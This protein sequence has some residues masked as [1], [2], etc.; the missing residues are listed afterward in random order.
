MLK[1]F[2]EIQQIT[3]ETFSTSDELEEVDRKKLLL[4]AKRG[5][6]VILDV[7]P[8]DEFN[9]AHIPYAVSVPLSSLQKYLKTLPKNKEIVAYCRGPYCFLAKDAV[10]LLRSKGF[11]A[12]R[13]KDSIHD[14]AA[15]GLPV[16]KAS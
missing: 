1:R 13:L 5:E 14:W 15:K 10:E 2:I 12:V 6:V 9:T 11:K 8:Q 3:D 16:S 7:R 4:R